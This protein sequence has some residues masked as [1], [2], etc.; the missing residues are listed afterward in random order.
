MRPPNHSGGLQAFDKPDMTLRQQL[1]NRDRLL[2]QQ[3]KNLL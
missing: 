2:H 1:Y 3:L